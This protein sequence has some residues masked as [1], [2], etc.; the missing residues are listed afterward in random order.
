MRTIRGR[1]G[2]CV[3]GDSHHSLKCLVLSDI[4]FPT[5]KTIH[6]DEIQAQLPGQIQIQ[7]VLQ[8]HIWFI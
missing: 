7:E 1:V 2:F 8:A 4:S 3:P 6:D 5:L